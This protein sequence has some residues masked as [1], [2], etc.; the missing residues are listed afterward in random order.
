M[1]LTN[2]VDILYL[3]FGSVFQRL[4]TLPRNCSHYPYCPYIPSFFFYREKVSIIW[5]FGWIA[6]KKEKIF[7]SRYDVFSKSFFNNDN[8]GPLKIITWS[9]YFGPLLGSLKCCR[10]VF[11]TTLTKVHALFYSQR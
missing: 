2:F 5:Y 7:V 3:V 10:S 8:N 1:F 9:N 4:S 11:K 6:I